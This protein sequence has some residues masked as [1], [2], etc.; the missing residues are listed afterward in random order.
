MAA[1]LPGVVPEVVS[2]AVPGVVPGPAARLVLRPARPEDGP[3]MAR[4]LRPSDRAELLAVS[5]D[6]RL[7]HRLSRAVAASRAAW[8]LVRHGEPLCLFGLAATQ[9][10]GVG[11][12]WLVGSPAMDRETVA[13]ARLSRVVVARFNQLFPVL[14]NL[15]DARNR[16]ALRWAAWAGFTVAARPQ[17][18]GP[19]GLPFH[20]ILKERGNHV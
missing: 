4:L 11:S 3:A 18:Y 10:P 16:R 15:V 5:P 17:P 6:P 19:L 7:G 2:G 1:V 8:L 9:A 20:R 12:P 14:V 13:L